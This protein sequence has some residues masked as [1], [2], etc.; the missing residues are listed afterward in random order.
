MKRLHILVSGNVQGVSY[1]Y[2]SKRKA[3]ELGLVG[4]VKN[5]PTGQVEIVVQGEEKSL[6][7]F[8]DWCKQGPDFADVDNISSEERPP[9]E[10]L[11]GFKIHF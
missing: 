6:Q 4:W 3:K 7:E 8:I 5:L 11:R 1:R 2:N 9:K 10:G